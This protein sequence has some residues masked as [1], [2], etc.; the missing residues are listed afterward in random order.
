MSKILIAVLVLALLATA[1]DQGYGFNT[2]ES[3]ASMEF[4]PNEHS[5]EDR[6]ARYQKEFLE[7]GKKMEA[8][9]K[10]P[11]ISTLRSAKSTGQDQ[12]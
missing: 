3:S 6:A 1:L 10:W 9:V 4:S 12:Q 2:E 5:V 11:G 7:M 8:R